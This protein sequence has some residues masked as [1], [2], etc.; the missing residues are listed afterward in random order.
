MLFEQEQ[1]K[2][3]GTARVGIVQHLFPKECAVQVAFPDLDDGSFVTYNLPVLQHGA[4]K[5]WSSYWMPAI[6]DQV[7]CVFLP[8]SPETGF[9]VGGFWAEVDELPTENENERRLV[10]D[11]GDYCVYNAD[12]RTFRVQAGETYVEIK[13]GEIKAG[14]GKEEALAIASKVKAELDGIKGALDEL[15]RAFNS[16][17][18]SYTCGTAGLLVTTP[19]P[20]ATPPTTAAHTYNAQEV[21]TSILKGE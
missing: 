4:G 10:A 1:S 19:A 3:I 16:H 21:N 5:K 8:H 11:N 15:Q 6:G 18:H 17:V 9:V 12:S 7:L 20:E 13:D 2:G 14:N